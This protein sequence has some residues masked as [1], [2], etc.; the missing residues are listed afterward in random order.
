MCPR[1]TSRQQDAKHGTRSTAPQSLKKPLALNFY[2]DTPAEIDRTHLI[3]NKQ[4]HSLYLDTHFHVLPNRKAD[5]PIRIGVLSG[6]AP[7]AGVLLRAQ[8]ERRWGSARLS[9]ADPAR[10]ASRNPKGHLPLTE[11]FPRALQVRIATATPLAAPFPRVFPSSASFAFCSPPPVTPAE[12]C[13]L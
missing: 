12:S 2:L 7:R 10:V 13:T 3:E 6:A 11:A 9:P 5:D 4:N 1:S 8:P